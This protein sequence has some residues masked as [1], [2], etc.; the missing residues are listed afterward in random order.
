M[1][2]FKSNENPNPA[3]FDDRTWIVSTWTDDG[4]TIFGLTHNEYQAQKHIGRC[5]FSTYHACWYNTIGLVRSENGGQLFRRISKKPIAAP[6]FPQ[7]ANQGRPRGFFS[8]SNIVK[9][10]IYKYVFIRTD[11][12]WQPNGT[13]L[14]RAVD[15]GDIFSWSYFSGRV[16]VR[17]TLDPYRDDV[18]GVSPCRPVAN[19]G[20]SVG[21]VVR[22]ETN[23]LFIATSAA[24]GPNGQGRVVLSTSS[25]LLNWSAPAALMD[26]PLATS[27]DC[28][29]GY[30]F[31]YPAFL[32]PQSSSINFDT[33]SDEPFLYLSRIRMAGCEMTRERD[34]VR[35]RL[36][37]SWR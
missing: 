2:V 3:E 30:K 1:I 18:S 15:V 33:T 9:Y 31:A 5:R 23:G 36:R 24:T 20:G 10:G 21:S 26:L 25:D 22:S 14:F 32:D 37:L 16:F 19:L 12:D 29:Q 8:P 11:G 13:C 6:P 4:K 34:L 28:N 7:E 27:T 35:I 17:S